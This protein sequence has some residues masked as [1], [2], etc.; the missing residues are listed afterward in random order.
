MANLEDIKRRQE[1]ANKEIESRQPEKNPTRPNT[2]TPPPANPLI[3][4]FASGF[5]GLP[6][7]SSPAFQ[8]LLQGFSADPGRTLV[9][10]G[11]TANW[12]TTIK[13]WGNTFATQFKNL[14]GRE[15]TPE[16]YNTFFDQVVNVHAPWQNAANVNPT[17]L[18]AETKGLL[19]DVFSSTIAQEAENKA[20][21]Q[22]TQATASWS[23]FDLW[24][25]EYTQGISDVERSLQDYQTRLFE[26]IRPQLMTSL[27]AQGLLDTGALNQAFA[28]VAGDLTAGSQNFIAQAR[29]AANQDIANRKYDIMS[30]PSNFALQNTFAKVPNLQASGQNAL[31]NVWNNYM[32]MNA[33][34]QQF[35]NQRSLLNEQ[36]ANQPSLLSQYAGQILGGAAGGFASGGWRKPSGSIV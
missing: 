4:R 23:P 3:E 21:Q 20:Q 16:E 25:Q 29:G 13:G 27:K 36:Y 26:K 11:N 22:A 18:G 12:Q 8:A 28:G 14:A 9:N 6:Y 17:Q 10:E 15:P 7:S 5:S 35:Q 32:G 31:Q 33:A 30:Q 1:E 24:S 2:A 34:N 19:Q